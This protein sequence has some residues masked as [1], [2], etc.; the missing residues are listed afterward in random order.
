M[1][2]L[3]SYCRDMLNLLMLILKDGHRER[4]ETCVHFSQLCNMYLF[5]PL[6]SQW[7][8]GVF[9]F[10][11]MLSTVSRFVNLT[12][13]VLARQDLFLLSE[14]AQIE[15]LWYREDL[16]N[17]LV[18]EIGKVW[19][20]LFQFLSVDSLFMQILGPESGW[21]SISLTEIITT[22]AVKKAYRKATL[23]V[24]PDKLQQRGASV[25]QKYICE[26]VFDLLKVHFVGV[27]WNRNA[28]T[29]VSWFWEH[30]TRLSH[31]LTYDVTECTF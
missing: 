21:Q 23:C 27:S 2:W 29:S 28:P 10:I 16:N 11:C 6:L 14:L 1:T 30:Y 12:R 20:K 18:E 8:L 17:P 9:M 22:A 24:H 26:K 3:F 25:Q 13:V 4:R 15:T 31:Y 19:Y 7:L 5:P